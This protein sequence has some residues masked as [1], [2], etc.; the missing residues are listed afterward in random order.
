MAKLQS[1]FCNGKFTQTGTITLLN[2]IRRDKLRATEDKKVRKTALSVQP[3]R[4][5]YCAMAIGLTMSVYLEKQCR[6]NSKTSSIGTP[7]M[8]TG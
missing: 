6:Q 4:I 2:F 8:E 5:A 1:K 7:I 3:G